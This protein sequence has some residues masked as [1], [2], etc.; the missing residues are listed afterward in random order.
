MEGLPYTQAA[1]QPPPAFVFVTQALA[2]K[3]RF[4]FVNVKHQDVVK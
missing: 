4:A 1:L 3:V 2:A